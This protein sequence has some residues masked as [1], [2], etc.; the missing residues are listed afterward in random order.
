MPEPMPCN[1]A[2]D[3]NIENDAAERA[4]TNG[5]VVIETSLAEERMKYICSSMFYAKKLQVE[6]LL[7][8]RL[9]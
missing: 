7:L 4:F 9:R 3:P 8:K 1:P 5:L 6:T 2:L